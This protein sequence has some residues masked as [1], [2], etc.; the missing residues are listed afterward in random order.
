MELGK[1]PNILDLLEVLSTYIIRIICSTYK[2][3]YSF[4][5]DNTSSCSKEAVSN[6]QTNSEHSGLDRI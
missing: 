6:Y 3:V 2:Q 5:S 1:T 4:F